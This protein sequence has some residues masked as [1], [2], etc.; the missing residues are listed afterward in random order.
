MTEPIEAELVDDDITFRFDIDH[1]GLSLEMGAWSFSFIVKVVW[2][3]LVRGLNLLS[4]IW[5]AFLAM[6]SGQPI[7]H[8]NF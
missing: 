6:M 4:N 7:P 5:N 3:A 2:D 1:Q 8:F